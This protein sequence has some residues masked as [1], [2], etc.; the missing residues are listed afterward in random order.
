MSIFPV[1]KLF[2][3]LQNNYGRTKLQKKIFL[4]KLKGHP[5]L[6]VTGEFLYSQYRNKE[7]NTWGLRIYFFTDEFSLKARS[8]EPYLTVPAAASANL[9]EPKLA[10]VNHQEQQAK[11]NLRHQITA[12]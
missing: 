6:F 2:I 3:P 8:L 4:T 10:N 5:N 7:E 9:Q 12:N 1:Y 11:L